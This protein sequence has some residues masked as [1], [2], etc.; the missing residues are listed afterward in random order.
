MNR[1]K[2]KTENIFLE[3][4]LLIALIA[5][6]YIFYRKE[7][8]VTGFISTLSVKHLP[9]YALRS[10]FR[11]TC[12][13]LLALLFSVLYGFAA[14]TSER[15]ARIMLPVLDIF[16]S[17]PILAFFPAAIFFFIAV[18]PSKS[19]GIEIA[20]IFLIF[21]SQVWN[22]AFGIYES[23]STIPKNIAES[24]N[25]FDP[26]GR[27]RT[28]RLLFPAIIPKL[29]Y[30]SIISWTN[31]WYFL[32]AC[33]IFAV[34][35][36]SYRLPGLGSFIMETATQSKISLT[37]LGILVLILII[38]F[39][40]LFIWKPLSQW[41]RRFR[42]DLSPGEEEESEVLEIVKTFWRIIGNILR[43][44]KPLTARAENNFSQILKITQNRVVHKCSVVFSKI[45]AI[46][47]IAAVSY[48][49]Y[50]LARGAPSIINEIT[51]LDLVATLKGLLFSFTRLLIAYLISLA[52]T[53]PVAITMFYH[54]RG[55]KIISPFI[56]IFAS[57]PAVAIFPLFLYFFIQ[58]PN[59]L[60]ITAIILILTGMQW[61]LLFNIFGGLK[62]IPGDVKEVV[63]SF[64][65][66]KFLKFKRLLFPA[67]LPSLM[68]GT[69]TAW[70]G[71][72]NA[73]IIAEYI[74]LQGK[75]YSVPGIGSILNTSL[76]EDK[77]GI[78][79]VALLIM[80]FAIFS[81]NHF[82]YRPLYAKISERFTMEV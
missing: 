79:I 18:I 23:L 39:I 6:A 69:I 80:V 63:D 16:Q 51:F 26:Q 75:I 40:D 64:K 45:I 3:L 31:G 20:A 36:A 76:N 7:I 22:I 35:R 32:V 19:I 37:L 77:K 5:L 53:L 14:A 55:A 28:R 15:R 1:E 73:L 60:N 72:W 4:F 42:Y 57:I 27:L 68:T 8:S 24:Y 17:V 74:S 41:S 56:Q 62:A 66:T 50:L 59:G 65:P 9:S 67:S 2:A 54:P 34:G 33:E 58:I 44:L 82:V 29:V 61:Y 81:I 47:I 71:G 70:G 25:F 38:I 78:F 21:T 52:W 30:N 46:G 10:L 48:L 11:M 49:V 13:Y 43:K 12:A